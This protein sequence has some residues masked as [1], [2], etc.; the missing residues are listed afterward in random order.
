MTQESLRAAIGMVTQDTSLLHRSIAANIRY[1][2]PSASEAEVVAA[3]RKAQAH[4]FIVHAARLARPGRLRRARRRARREAVGRAAAARR[5]RARDLE[6][7]ADPRAGRGDVGARQ[8]GRARDPGTALGPD[9]R[10]D[11]HRDRASAFDDC[12]HGSARR[13][14]RRQGRR[15]GHARGAAAPRRPLRKALAAP[16]RRLHRERARRARRRAAAHCGP[17][18]VNRAAEARDEHRRLRLRAPRR[19]DPR[20]LERCDRELDGVVRLQAAR[21]GDDGRVVPREDGASVSGAR[22]CRRRRHVAWASRPTARFA[23]GP[24]TSTRSSTRS[25]CTRTIAAR[26]SRARS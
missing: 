22:R 26:A 8:R 14:R 4:D 23:P 21:A 2:K 6:R 11:R 17:P 3:A 18:S 10:Q 15:G 13:A 1:G 5:A 7:R 25:T 9:A 24:R 19:G 20:D 12:A 16:I